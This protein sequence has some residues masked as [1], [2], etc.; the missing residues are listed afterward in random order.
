MQEI[1]DVKNEKQI[2]RTCNHIVRG[3]LLDTC[4]K[5]NV[6]KAIQLSLDNDEHVETVVLMIPGND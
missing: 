5:K 3:Y 1:T 6:S 2:I 4:Y